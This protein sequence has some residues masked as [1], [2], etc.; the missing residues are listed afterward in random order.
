MLAGTHEL[1]DGSRARLR[2]ARPNDLPR[3]QAFLEGLGS[4][5]RARHFAFYDP[6]ERLAIAAT[7]PGDGG[8]QVVGMADLALVDAD[9]AEIDVVVADDRRGA[10]VGQL[11]SGAVASLALQ[12]GARRVKV[13]RL[14]ADG[15]RRAA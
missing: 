8:E 13:G 11:L 5:T 6:R 9:M 3:I 7:M 4:E 1:A 15:R 14:T 10:G 12:R 2:L